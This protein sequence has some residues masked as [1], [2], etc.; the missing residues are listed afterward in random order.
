M[1][2]QCALTYERRHH[3]KALVVWPLDLWRDLPQTLSKVDFS[4]VLCPVF[5]P[6]WA[7]RVVPPS[8]ALVPGSLVGEGTMKRMTRGQLHQFFAGK[9]D[10][11]VQDFILF[12][13][14][15]PLSVS[16]CEVVKNGLRS[17][18]RGLPG[19][20]RRLG[21]LWIHVH[22]EMNAGFVCRRTGP[23]FEIYRECVLALDPN[24]ELRFTKA[25]WRSLRSNTGRAQIMC[26]YQSTVY[27]RSGPEDVVFCEDLGRLLNWE[28]DS[29]SVER[30]GR[31][32][33]RFMSQAHE[34]R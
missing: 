27:F 28:V 15:S 20:L 24:I 22:D 3:S 31:F 21:G 33:P 16:E 30:A 11:Q 26:G 19:L 10:R 7:D 13:H 1:L 5:H 25:A 18:R 2:K 6:F 32:I 17:I 4:E 12:C 34:R 8:P 9:R 23:L 14:K 29:G